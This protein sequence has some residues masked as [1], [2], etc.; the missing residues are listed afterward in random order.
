MREPDEKGRATKNTRI[1]E[2]EGERPTRTLDNG[3]CWR[4]LLALNLIHR[5]SKLVGVWLGRFELLSLNLI[6][7]TSKLVASGRHAKRPFA[8]GGCYVIWQESQEGV[9]KRLCAGRIRGVRIDPTRGSAC[10]SGRIG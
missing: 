4:A 5:T 2:N 10:V 3:A 7:R 6:H 8:E 9:N 1:P